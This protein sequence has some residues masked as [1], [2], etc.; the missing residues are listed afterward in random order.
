MRFGNKPSGCNWSAFLVAATASAALWAVACTSG[1]PPRTSTGSGIDPTAVGTTGSEGA[2]DDAD[3]SSSGA[4]PMPDMSGPLPGDGGGSE[5]TTSDSDSFG[6]P[7]GCDLYI[8]DCPAGEKCTLGASEEGGLPDTVQCVPVSAQAQQPGD[9]CNAIDP[10]RGEDDCAVG[11]FCQ[12]GPE[13]GLPGVCIS[14]CAGGPD[15]ASCDDPHQAC[16]LLLGGLAPVCLYT[17]E[18]G[19]CPQGQACGIL[20]PGS[21]VCVAPGWNE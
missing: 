8:Q 6:D 1:A 15:E 11:S 21:P 2:T 7:S 5:S 16:G 9:L 10:V 4:L 13:D 17:C 20:G 3:A 19:E 18:G 14:F 12:L